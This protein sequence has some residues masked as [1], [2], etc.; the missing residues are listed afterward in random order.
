MKTPKNLLSAFTKE[1]AFLIAVHIDPDGDAIGSALALSSAL[2]SMGKKTSVFSRD[3]V[4]K[5]YR[6]LAG[7]D[8]FSP[9]L[10][11]IMKEDPVLVLVDCNSPVRAAV[12]GHSFRKSIV[13]DHHETEKDFGD[14][15]WIDRTSAATGVMIFYLLKAL[16]VAITKEIAVHLYTA[17]SVDT[18]TFR[19]SNTTADV[20]RTS[21]ELVAAGADPG[22]VAVKLYESWDYKRFRLLVM[23][24]NTLEVRNSVAVIHITRNMYK[25]TGTR[26]EDTEHFSNFPR[27]IG[28]IRMAV[29]LRELDSGEWKASLRARGSVNVARLAEKFGGGGHENAAGFK[30]KADLNAVKEILFGAVPRSVK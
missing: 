27:M 8:R 22:F 16:H 30:I 13:I 28:S 10:K 5:Y 17:I 29:L 1:K 19:Y 9:G 21:A 15:R 6:F 18:G 4:P 11:G 7:H 20:L 3:P 24:L 26:S 14:I 23:A 25:E 2:E 12:E